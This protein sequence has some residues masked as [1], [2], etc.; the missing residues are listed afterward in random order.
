LN[1]ECSMFKLL[2]LKLRLNL[3]ITLKLH[4]QVKS[5]ELSVSRVMEFCIET[6]QSESWKCDSSLRTRL[7]EGRGCFPGNNSGYRGNTHTNSSL[8]ENSMM[9]YNQKIDILSC[10]HSQVR[11]S[12][13]HKD[14]R[15]SVQG[16]GI[17]GCFESA[18]PHVPHYTSLLVFM[19]DR[20]PRCLKR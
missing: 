18:L 16:Y 15:T 17:I 1:V 5:S 14:R 2:H 20:L 13:C 7:S 12:L 6:Q 3:H 19:K 11:G 4:I 8:I 9:F 10:K